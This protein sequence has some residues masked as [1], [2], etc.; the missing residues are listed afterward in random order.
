MPLPE[1]TWRGDGDATL[2]L[3]EFSD[4]ECPFCG[5]FATE[6]YPQIE[7]DYIEQGRLRYMFVDDP[8]EQMH[9]NAFKAHEAALCAGEQGK[10]W[11][12]HARLF[13]N[14][15]AL[16]PEALRS[17]AEAAGADGAALQA[18]LS[19]LPYVRLA[20]TTTGAPAAEKPAACRSAELRKGCAPWGP[21]RALGSP[22]AFCEILAKLLPISC[23]TV[24]R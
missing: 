5:R 15:K 18:C 19:A 11:E 14:Q 23:R 20:G 13:A 12:M 6:I 16:A 8:I 24:S 22:S 10:Y 1:G 17:H 3:L 21:L 7:R 2:A 9:P 4:F